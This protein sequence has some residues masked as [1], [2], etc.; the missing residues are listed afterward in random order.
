[1][2]FLLRLLKEGA[3]LLEELD[4]SDDQQ[5]SSID[6]NSLKPIVLF[7]D[8]A[9]YK[10]SCAQRIEEVENALELKEYLPRAKVRFGW[11][12]ICLRQ[13]G[14]LPNV[15]NM[16]ISSIFSD[17]YWCVCVRACA[18]VCVCA[19]V[20][21]CV[22]AGA[23]GFN[24]RCFFFGA[25]ISAVFVWFCETMLDKTLL[26]IFFFTFSMSACISGNTIW[27]SASVTT[28]ISLLR[29]LSSWKP[30][31]KLFSWICL[32][33]EVRLILRPSLS[34]SWSTPI[35]FLSSWLVDSD[36]RVYS[37][38]AKLVKQKYQGETAH[39]RQGSFF[40]GS[41]Q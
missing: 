34:L 10:D 40:W 22:H 33:I 12:W 41:K 6:K 37:H 14:Y 24:V 5:E 35:L 11:M 4:I 21:A 1:M 15:F 23:L 8:F 38:Q 17:Y 36:K 18:S 9:E 2:S 27:R 28:L 30:V 16:C 7:G 20:R 3:V 31:R 39:S 29:R 25:C 32:L 26:L 13:W 19:C